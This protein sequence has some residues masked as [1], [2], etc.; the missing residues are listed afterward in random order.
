MSLPLQHLLVFGI[1]AACLVFVAVQ[2]FSALRG[3]RS[4]LGNCCSKGCQPTPPAS[5]DRVVFLPA[6]L[7]RKR[8]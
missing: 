4:K 8:K 7:L 3:K 6:D 5:A 1:V 2:A